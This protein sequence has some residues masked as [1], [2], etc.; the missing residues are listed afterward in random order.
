MTYGDI[1]QIALAIAVLIYTIVIDRKAKKQ[2]I[3]E[4]KSPELLKPMEFCL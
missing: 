2:T 4:K 3:K 1:C